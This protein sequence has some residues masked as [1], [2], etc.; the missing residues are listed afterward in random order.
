MSYSTEEGPCWR[1]VSST[2]EDFDSGEGV[3][4]FQ[5]KADA[6]SEAQDTTLTV[7]RYPTPCVT[8][9][10]DECEADLESDAFVFH[11]EGGIPQAQE[12]ARKSDW[13]VKP[14]GR[15]YCWDCPAPEIEYA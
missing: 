10:C 13:T 6:Q 3:K 11:F 1:L 8:I 12:I 9:T 7:Q 4:H 14:D 2:G 15:L 5:S